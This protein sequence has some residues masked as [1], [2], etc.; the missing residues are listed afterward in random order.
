MR[1]IFFALLIAGTNAYAGGELEKPEA[2]YV[3]ECDNKRNA[4]AC[5]TMA[6][7]TVCGRGYNEQTA[8]YMKKACA[9]RAYHCE[10][11]DGPGCTAHAQC[12]LSCL[13]WQTYWDSDLPTFEDSTSGCHI[14][15]KLP[16]ETEAEQTQA[17]L[18][19]VLASL[20]TACAKKDSKGCF[21]LGW[22]SATDEIGAPS[23]AKEAWQKSCDLKS[24]EGCV[25]LSE[26]LEKEAKDLKKRACELGERSACGG[27]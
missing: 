7:Q 18:K 11:G 1:V 16:G 13:S 14:S 23:Q 12:V 4:A 20:K 6:E 5:E 27:R 25:A 26:R 9:H 22:L 17:G 21:L 19:R 24:A 10:G 15:L 2:F 8:A 3:D